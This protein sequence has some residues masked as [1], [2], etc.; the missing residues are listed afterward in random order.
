[1]R[2]SHPGC[3]GIDTAYL[4]ACVFQC[5]QCGGNRGNGS[6]RRSQACGRLVQR[7]SRAGDGLRFGGGHA[8]IPK[9]STVSFKFYY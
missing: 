2:D 4:V 1:M 8:E 5:K 9:A 3:R 6:P 7:E